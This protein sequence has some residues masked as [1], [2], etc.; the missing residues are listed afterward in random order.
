MPDGVVERKVGNPGELV[1]NVVELL[2]ISDA[3]KDFLADW[4][5]GDG[6]SGDDEIT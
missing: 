6:L 5:N 3:G 1:L 2:R 4:A